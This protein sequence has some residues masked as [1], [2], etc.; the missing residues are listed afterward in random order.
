MLQDH[1][2]LGLHGIAIPIVARHR[3]VGL[4]DQQDDAR[5]DLV[6]GEIDRVFEMSAPA[7]LAAVATDCAWS[8]ESRWL[9][10]QLLEEA[11]VVAREAREPHGVDMERTRAMCL[12][13]TSQNWRHR[14]RYASMFDRMRIERAVPRPEEL[15]RH[16]DG[17]CRPRWRP[18]YLAD[19]E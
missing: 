4:H 3:G 1:E 9:A 12:G 6:R 11:V 15:E 14:T 7:E 5:L 2:E 13:L 17:H 10:M 16:D 19:D 18:G 8:P